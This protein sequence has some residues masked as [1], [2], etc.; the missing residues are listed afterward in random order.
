MNKKDNELTE[1]YAQ[2]GVMTDP[3]LYAHMLDGLPTD[4]V[5]LCQV[6]QG[7]LIHI[8]WAERYGVTLTDAQKQTVEVRQVSRKLARIWQVVD[9]PLKGCS[10]IGETTGVYLPRLRD[11]VVRYPALSRR[12]GPSALRVRSIF[13]T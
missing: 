12:S 4:L 13:S 11:L 5:D 8:F 9:R 3:G 10:F 1:F 7:N 2:A 6:V